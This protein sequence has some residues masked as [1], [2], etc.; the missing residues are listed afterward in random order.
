MREMAG[1]AFL[2]Q[3]LWISPPRATLSPRPIPL[4]RGISIQ[5]M[6]QTLEGLAFWFFVP[7]FLPAGRYNEPTYFISLACKGT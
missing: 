4:K 5:Q 7:G 6:L 3:D 1:T 2:P